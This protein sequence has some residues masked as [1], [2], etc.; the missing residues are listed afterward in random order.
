[1]VRIN[2]INVMIRANMYLPKE[3]GIQQW[4]TDGTKEQ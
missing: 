3:K 1:M 4:Q 2:W